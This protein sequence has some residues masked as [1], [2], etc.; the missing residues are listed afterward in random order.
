MCQ[1]FNNFAYMHVLGCG[2]ATLHPSLEINIHP[3]TTAL[4][5]MDYHR[6][7]GWFSNL[8]WWLPPLDSKLCCN[9][10]LCR[11]LLLFNTIRCR[12]AWRQWK[13][14]LSTVDERTWFRINYESRLL[15]ANE[16]IR[17]TH[18]SINVVELFRRLDLKLNNNIAHINMVIHN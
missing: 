10:N 3:S 8:V 4:W 11:S 13:L 14:A 5:L 15:T 6:H 9:F 16:A 12:D 18:S 17:G 7:W 1:Y 2:L